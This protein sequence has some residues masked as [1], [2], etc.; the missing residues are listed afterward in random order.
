MKFEN[1][2]VLIT[3]G[4]SGIGKIMGRMAL[5]KGASC[6]I[7]WDINITNIEAT[8]QE[9]RKYGKVTGY[10]VDVS[11]NEIVTKAYAKVVEECGEIDILI[12]CAGI[13]TSNKTFANISTDEIVRTMN[14]NTIA[15]MFVAR[16]MLPAMLER[17]RGHI[18]TIASAGGMLSNPKMSVYAASKWGVIGW[19]DSVRI[20]L[21]EMKSNVHITTVAPYYINTGMFDGVKSRIIPI[22][23]PEYAARKVI[24]AIERNNTF[25]G[26]PFGFHFIRF[27][28]AILPT[29][30]FDFFFGEVFGIYHTMDAFTG[31]KHQGSLSSRAS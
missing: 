13:V 9:L 31:R 10:V 20:E 1:A 2:N 18:C 25:K 28:Q 29:R 17:N 27:W 30:I 22:L 11:N 14:I 3:G 5:E 7:I 16:A 4:A 15:P 23:K 6:L 19:S 24:Q 8:R 26:I 12:N 21:Q